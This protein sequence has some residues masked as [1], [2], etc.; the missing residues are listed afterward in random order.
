[1]S[2]HET[3]MTLAYWKEV[4]G[5]LIEEFRVVDRSVGC[6]HRDL[7]AVILPKGERRRVLPTERRSISLQGQDVIVVQAKASRLGMYLM[8]QAF[9]SV[10]LVRRLGVASVRTVALCTD[11]DEVLGPIARD[12]GIEVVKMPKPIP[13]P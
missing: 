8:G 2:K 5:T 9:F 13:P 6:G 1:M 3:P 7:D 12:H 11:Y 10:H 4:G